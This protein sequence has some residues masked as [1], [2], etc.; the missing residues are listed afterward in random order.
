M[1][2]DIR[3]TFDNIMSSRR[4]TSWDNLETYLKEVHRYT[5]TKYFISVCKGN[6]DDPTLKYFFVR[7]VCTHGR[8]RSSSESDACG[9][10]VDD[11]SDHH[12][13]EEHTTSNSPPQPRQ[14]RRR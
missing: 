6:S 7:Y 5:H 4:F 8:K 13:S 2:H 3:Q 1:M 14:R 11:D 9:Q 12:S 10:D